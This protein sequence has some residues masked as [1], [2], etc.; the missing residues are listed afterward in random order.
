METPAV[1]LTANSPARDNA[2]G[3]KGWLKFIGVLNIIAGAINALSLIGILWAWL[4]IWLG[5]LLVQAGS[6]ADEYAARGDEAA[7]TGLLAK[8]KN[9]YLISGIF[10]IIWLGII[11][12][13]GIVVLI[14][15]MAGM[16]S[17]PELME[18]L[19]SRSFGS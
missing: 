5:I 13:A 4:P 3:L 2:R 15:T 18:S 1:V 14:L 19:R 8:L 7:L 17:M 10:T 11:V 12:L 9:Y 16:L 6:R